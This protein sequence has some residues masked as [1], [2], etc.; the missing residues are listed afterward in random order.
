M[1]EDNREKQTY[2]EH[3]KISC[4]FFKKYSDKGLFTPSNIFQRDT[5]WHNPYLL[6]FELQSGNY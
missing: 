4:F 1:A 5:L 6:T 2:L 3:K